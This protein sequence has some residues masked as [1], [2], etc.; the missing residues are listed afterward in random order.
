[1]R[2]LLYTQVMLRGL[3]VDPRLGPETRGLLAGRTSLVSVAS[4]W[5]VAFQLRL[6]K[7]DVRHAALRIT[8]LWQGLPASRCWMGVGWK[9]RSCRCC[10]RILSIAC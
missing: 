10:I 6:G 2:L 7:L 4:I 1:M 5:E 3:L 8:A 9:K